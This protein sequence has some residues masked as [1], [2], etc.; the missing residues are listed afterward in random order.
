MNVAVNVDARRREGKQA[1]NNS[2]GARGAFVQHAAGR[3]G[4]R[5]KKDSVLAL[6]PLPNRNFINQEHAQG[7]GK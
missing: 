7:E 4:P 5:G 1:K 2:K 6:F 3:G